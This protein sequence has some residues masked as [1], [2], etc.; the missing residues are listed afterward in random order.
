MM[1][2]RDDSKVW[3]FQAVPKRYDILIEVP[4]RLSTA[5]KGDNWLVTRHEDEMQIGQRVL[6]WDRPLYPF[7]SIGNY[8]YRPNPFGSG[9]SRN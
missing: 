2:S 4:E 7:N 6:L 5:E 1:L 8:K 3:I 9:I